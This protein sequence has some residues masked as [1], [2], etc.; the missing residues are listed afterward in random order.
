MR[1]AAF[2]LLGC[3]AAGAQVA[4]KPDTAAEFQEK[5][6]PW[7]AR[8]SV[9]MFYSGS[10]ESAYQ[11][12][13]YQG[14]T[15]QSLRFAWFHVG[16]RTRETM[17][18]G[19]SRPYSEPVILKLSGTAEVLR[20]FVYVFLSGNLPL[21][22]DHVDVADTAAL[23]SAVG[24][25]GIFPYQNFLSPQGVHVGAVGRYRFPDWDVMAGGSYAR[26]GN[27]EPIEA[28][29][30]FPA[31][32]FDVFA[33]AL[34]EGR[35][36]RHRFDAKAVLYGE[37]SGTLR[38]AAHREGS[39]W[40]FRYGY[41]KFARGKSWQLGLGGAWKNPDLNRRLRIA[42]TL[43]PVEANDNV[44]RAYAEIAVTFAP[45]PTWLMRAHVIPQALFTPAQ[46]GFGYQTEAGLSWAAR[47][48]GVHRLRVAGTAVYGT[49]RDQTFIG[50]GLHAEFAFRHLGF[51]DLEDQ[52]DAEDPG[53]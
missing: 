22:S 48:W 29:S 5:G 47:L 10:P 11:I 8:S 25:Y 40:Q 4:D 39:L 12:S 17:A 27:F 37:E 33:R 18:P 50:L 20:D 3:A 14:I 28:V 32:Y 43:Q 38:I 51:Q 35:A 42:S 44:Q 23:A 1:A 21:V 6:I 2:L 36:A 26:A 13:A 31:A 45:L 15:L 49:F 9:D 7:I 46:A 34:Y 52:G 41:L 16:M 19:F 30:F 24:D 53:R